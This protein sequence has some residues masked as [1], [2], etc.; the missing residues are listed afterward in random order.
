V[1]SEA[2]TSHVAILT[3]RCNFGLY[4]SVHDSIRHRTLGVFNM[5]IGFI[6]E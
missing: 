4:L 3:S 6:Y 2:L 5:P 1:R